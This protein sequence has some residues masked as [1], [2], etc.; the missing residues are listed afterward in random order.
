M[1][2]RSRSYK[3]GLHRRLKDNAEAGNY[4]QA[5]LEDSQSAF[6]VALKNVLE[7]RNIT[8]VARASALD[9]VH[10][11]RMLSE[12]GNPTLNSLDKILHALGLKLAIDLEASASPQPT[13][14]TDHVF[15]MTWNV[16][17]A[18]KR[19]AFVYG[20]VGCEQVLNTS[21][22]VSYPDVPHPAFIPEHEDAVEMAF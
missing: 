15:H 9:R 22:Q 4:L 20:M 5:A 21:V 16:R 13:S 7:A 10:I 11:Y 12:G 17:G 19:K 14:V 3:D 8:A 1:S 6:L 18:H 2:G